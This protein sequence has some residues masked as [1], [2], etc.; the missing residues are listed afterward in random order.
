MVEPA[1]TRRAGDAAGTPCVDGTRNRRIALQGRMSPVLVVVRQVPRQD[2]PQVGLAQDDD[3]AEALSASLDDLR[4]QN[5]AIERRI[6]GLL[7]RRMQR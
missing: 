6:P 7:R 5:E 4:K 1:D 2:P 3:V